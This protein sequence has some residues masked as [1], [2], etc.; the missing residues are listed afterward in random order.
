MR[1]CQ[2][3]GAARAAVRPPALCAGLRSL[4]PSFPSFS[5][6][7]R[8]SHLLQP[9][10]HPIRFYTETARRYQ[11][12]RSLA[13]SQL[14]IESTSQEVAE[15]MA[16]SSKSVSSENPVE[17]LADVKPDPEE[18]ARL[19][20]ASGLLHEIDIPAAAANG[21]MKPHKRRAAAKTGARA[22]S[23]SAAAAAVKCEPAEPVAADLAASIQ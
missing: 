16:G 18:A 5:R 9:F 20:A 17:G 15:Q 7:V 4:V 8:L 23:E 19:T 2:T 22:L 11:G 14:A 3:S 6:P 13:T 21:V 1:I 12:T 10:S